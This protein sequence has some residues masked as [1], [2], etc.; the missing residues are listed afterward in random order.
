MGRLAVLAERLAVVGGQDHERAA[1]LALLEDRPQQRLERRVGRGD[2]AVVGVR[3]AV[4]EGGRGHVRRVRLVEVDEREA[5]PADRGQPARGLGHRDGAGTLRHL[6]AAAPLAAR[7]AG[8]PALEAAREPEALVEHERAHEAAAA[9]AARLQQRGER[10][11]VLGNAEAVVVADAVLEGMAAGEH[12]HVRGQRDDV[13]GVRRVE[14][15]ARA[16]QP[17]DPRRTRP[18]VPVGAERVGA[19]RVDRDQQYRELRVAR[20]RQRLRHQLRQL[21]PDPAPVDLPPVDPGRE[22]QGHDRERHQDAERGA[23][24]RLLGGEVGARERRRRVLLL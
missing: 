19:Q 2:L 13:V 7:H 6:E 23:R 4:G 16:R 1:V 10:R 21:P 22:G 24:P 12:V 11:R 14:A 17:I 18:R 3:R 5:R 8:V 20:L 15:H 9:M